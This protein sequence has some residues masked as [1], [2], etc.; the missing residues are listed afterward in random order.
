MSDPN[1]NPDSNSPGGEAQVWG[2][3]PRPTAGQL[4]LQEGR[5]QEHRVTPHEDPAGRQGVR[6]DLAPKGEEA[7]HRHDHALEGRGGYECDVPIASAGS[8]PVSPG[9]D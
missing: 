9:G 1:P 8:I 4:L 7:H 2:A 6:Q 3:G 5:V